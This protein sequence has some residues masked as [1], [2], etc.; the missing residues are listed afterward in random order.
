MTNLRSPRAAG[1]AGIHGY[2]CCLAT[3]PHAAEELL[4]LPLLLG[5]APSSC[6]PTLAPLTEEKLLCSPE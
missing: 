5:A 6:H 4:L 2:L 1:D 3:P